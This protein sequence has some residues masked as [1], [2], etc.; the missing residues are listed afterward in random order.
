[1]GMLLG[2]KLHDSLGRQSLANQGNSHNLNYLIKLLEKK[3]VDTLNSDALYTSGIEGILSNLDPH[4]VYIPKENLE[5]VNEEL[6][7]HF[8]GIGVEFFV[9]N[10]TVCISN[11]LKDGPSFNTSLHAGDRILKINDSVIAGRKLSQENIIKKIRGRQNTSV[12]LTV[13]H[14]DATTEIVN[15]TRNSIPIHS[16]PAYF[17]LNNNTGY[18]LISVF[19]ETTYDEFVAALKVLK[20]KGIEKLVIDVR[21]NPGGYMN[22]VT[23][24]ADELIAGKHTLLK[25]KGKNHS[26]ELKTQIDGI[27]E[28]GQIAILIN[29]NSASASEI[30]AGVIQDLDRG[31]IIG[32]RSYGKGLVQ[33][34]YELPNGA[35]IR[36]TTARYYLPSGRCIQ[37]SYA[38]GNEQYKDDIHQ[39]FVKG[40]LNKK[41]T[42]FLQQNKDP[43]LTLNKRVVY[44][45]EGI[46]PDIFVPL[47]TFS[48]KSLHNFYEKRVASLFCTSYYYKQPNLFKNLKSVEEFNSKFTLDNNMATDFFKF[49]ILLGFTSNEAT[50]F[51]NSSKVQALLKAEFAKL[52]FEYSGYY[53]VTSQYDS[54][55]NTSLKALK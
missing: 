7:G 9:Y 44:G 12:K 36:I 27:F 37:R 45:D 24:I 5:R 8:Y 32:R 43:F 15:I 48:Y 47:D 1:M 52:A 30:L 31:I 21:N 49:I 50:T 11:I 14:P 55:V 42:S 19:S 34:Q 38:D 26:E 41:D 54:I 46:N 16:V 23:K 6:E 25:T 33:E 39:R 13:L 18:I 2:Y 35:A 4:T 28:Q 29:E 10:D 22:A 20:S 53:V 3:Y 40:E 51:W 17:K